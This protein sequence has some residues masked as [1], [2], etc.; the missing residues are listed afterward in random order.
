MALIIES[1]RVM[2]LSI[3]L[4]DLQRLIIASIAYYFAI[5]QL[6]ASGCVQPRSFFKWTSFKLVQ[7]LEFMLTTE[8][9][10]NIDIQSALG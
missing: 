5:K 8:S 6:L 3:I 10:S 9:C 1:F 4:A 2:K 7:R